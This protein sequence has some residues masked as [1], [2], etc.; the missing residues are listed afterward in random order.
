MPNS[1]QDESK[2]ELRFLEEI[3]TTL[4][5]QMIPLKWQK[6]KRNKSGLMRVKGM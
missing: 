6:L 5:M 1:R 4:Y 2:L 3:S